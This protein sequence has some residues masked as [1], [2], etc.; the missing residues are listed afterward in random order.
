[1]K[2]RATLAALMLSTVAAMAAVAERFHATHDEVQRA[3]RPRRDKYGPA[4]P[5]VS[6]AQFL[7]NGRERFINTPEAATRHRK[8][9]LDWSLTKRAPVNRNS[10]AP[11][12]IAIAYLRTRGMTLPPD[13]GAFANHEMYLSA[14]ED[15]RM[16]RNRRK[17]AR[18][19]LRAAGGVA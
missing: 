15:H 9:E 5:G 10:V 13:P 8:R 2:G 19:A 1:M 4:E 12:R 18:R 6:K 17:A 14:V 11:H 16:D 3:K 7:T